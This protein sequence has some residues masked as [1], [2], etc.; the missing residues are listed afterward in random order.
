MSG[1]SGEMKHYNIPI[2]IPHL[3]CP[4]DCIY[5]DQKKITAQQG[6]PDI[7]Q[8]IYTIEEYLQTIP[9]EAH[10]EVAFFGGNFTA[11]DRKLQEDYLDAVQPYLQQERVQSIRI[12]T[13]PD[14][15]DGPILDMLANY[16]VKMIELGV[17]SLSDRVL[18]AS[19]RNYRPEDVFKS[20][21]LIR[22]RQF[23]LGI[24]LMIGLPQDSYAMDMQTARQTIALQPQA[25]RIYPTLV[26][27]GTVLDIMWQ[28]GE[29][30]PLSL[31]EAVSTCADMLLLFQEEKIRVIR[32][33]LYPGEE[34]RRDG[35]I[36]AGPFHPSFGELVDQEIF[37]Q[38]ALFAIV[39]YFESF[40]HRAEINLHVNSRD[41][42]KMTG[43]KQKNLQEL[44]RELALDS[45]KLKLDQ[46]LDR[47]WVGVSATDVEEAQLLLS[48]E[49][50]IKIRKQ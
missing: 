33:G 29:Y 41:I 11:V 26:I 27:A 8:M 20:S 22:E 18:Q 15:I 21:H 10:V 16:G 1:F 45:I 35:V 6:T 19:A 40:G 32:M 31:E 37:K 44:K 9:C 42:S 7:K 47:N 46:V 4:Y 24:Q 48:R 5:C 23:D 36:Q 28:R 12:S 14:C 43:K 34:L 3:G 49:E 13:R 30:E 17:Q 50:F 25:V 38:Q 2:F 39:Q